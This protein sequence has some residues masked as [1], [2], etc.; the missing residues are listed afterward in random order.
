MI[1]QSGSKR[2][3]LVGWHPSVVDYAKFPGLTAEK[4]EAALLG[5]EA[6]LR[7]LGYD[8]S[9]LFLRDAETAAGDILARL[10]AE[11]FSIILIGAGV[12]KVEEHFLTF[13]RL[14]NLVHE[15]APKARIAFN[16]NP[17]DTA[18]AVQRWDTA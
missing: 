11:H 7:A 8:A 3:L 9:W 10:K 5:D 15:H 14:V 12:R 2:V 16:T 1:D 4:L 18:E 17:S 6:K 13:E